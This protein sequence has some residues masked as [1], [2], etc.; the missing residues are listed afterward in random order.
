MLLIACA[1]VANLTLSRSAG[2]EKEIGIRTALGAGRKR[3]TRQLL[4]ESVVLASL[5]GFLGLGF[6]IGGL[7]L[8][9]T[10]LPGRYTAV[11]GRADGLARLAFYRGNHNSYR[12]CFWSGAGASGFARWP[13]RFAQV[14]W[15]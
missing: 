9:K 12:I 15:S 4:T 6:A 10:F 1:N 14:W 3:I 7:R 13:Q 5:G 2:R 8:L 11:D